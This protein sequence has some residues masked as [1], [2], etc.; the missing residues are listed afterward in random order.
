MERVEK[1]AVLDNEIQAQLIDNVLTDRGIPHVLRSYHDSVYDG[2][3]QT[4]LGW[5]HLEAPPSFR[6]EVLDVI[7]EIKRQARS[8]SPEGVDGEDPQPGGSSP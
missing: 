7:E 1:V 8:P 3:F 2:L 6:Q 5:G 4:G